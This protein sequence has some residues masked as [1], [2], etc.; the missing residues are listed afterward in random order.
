MAVLTFGQF[1]CPLGYETLFFKIP[2]L[3]KQAN[4][5]FSQINTVV[6]IS[7]KL[8]VQFLSP[9]VHVCQF[10]QGSF[11]QHYMRDYCAQQ[12]LV[13]ASCCTAHNFQKVLVSRGQCLI[14]KLRTVLCFKCIFHI[15]LLLR[16]YPDRVSVYD[17]NIMV[18]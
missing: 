3:T 14:T 16:H 9:S 18:L 2:R 7:A 10:A 11:S 6:C 8:A 17:G 15:P 13:K 5:H 4:L 12:Q 1:P